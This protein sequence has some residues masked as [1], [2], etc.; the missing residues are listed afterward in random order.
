[1]GHEKIKVYRWEYGKILEKE[2]N[3]SDLK[4]TV[5]WK[6]EPEEA[7]LVQ[8]KNK[9]SILENDITSMCDNIDSI[10]LLE[11]DLI[12]LNIKRTDIPQE[13][14]F[15]LSKSSIESLLSKLNLLLERSE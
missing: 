9:K 12:Q 1:M 3:K 15:G 7:M 4:S 10:M 11:D 6:A 2:I 14:N 13:N 5:G 8:L